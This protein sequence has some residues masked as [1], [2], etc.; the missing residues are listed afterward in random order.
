MPRLLPSVSSLA[1]LACSPA[2]AQ[3]SAAD[4]WAE[5][6]ATSAAMGQ[7]MT[8]TV[9]PDRRWPGARQ[10]R[11]PDRGGRHDDDWNAGPRDHD[12]MADGSVSVEISN[13][14]VATIMFPE[15]V[16]GPMITVEILVNHEGSASPS[17]ARPTRGPMSIPPT[18]SPSARAISATTGAT[19]RPRSTWKSSPATWPRPTLSPARRAANSASK[20]PA[21]SGPSPGVSTSSAAGRG[22]APEG[23]L[24]AGRDEFDASGS[25]VA[26]ARCSR[27]TD[28]LPEGFEVDGTTV[29]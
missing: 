3:V 15:D 12:G 7:E 4:L 16:G 2:M 26:L 5:W 10:L 1:I 11:D 8:A 22:R 14:Y 23:E 20:A 18:S 21:A 28:G 24:R 13:P 19:R 29:L 17:P 27:T 9:D 6:Q 25:I